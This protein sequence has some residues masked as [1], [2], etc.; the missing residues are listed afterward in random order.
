MSFSGL[1][2]RDIE[3][4]VAIA[5]AGSFTAAAERCGV[6]QPSLSGQ[7]RK[8]EAQL[9]VRIFERTGRDVRVTA[10]GHR[11]IEQA[12]TVLGEARRLFDIARTLNDPLSGPLRLGVIATLGPYLVP[13]LLGPIRERFPD[14]RLILREGLTAE[15]SAL[16]TSGEIDAVLLSLPVEDDR[17][18]AFPILFER[19]I[20]ICSTGSSFAH[21]S[22]LS[23]DDLDTDDLL[24]MD[25]GHCIRD[26][27]LA[28]CAR[29]RAS[30]SVR[31]AASIET[32]RHLVAAG[33]GHALM[34]GL[35]VRQDPLLDPHIAYIPL[36]DPS[37]G[38]MIGLAW[39]K[40]DVRGPSFQELGA[41][42]AGLGIGK[43]AEH[44]A[45]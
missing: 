29:P 25:E 14:L 23:L 24:L 42:I 10:A 8:V 17:L 45:P 22:S 6:S 35:A 16:V 1:S 12:R 13:H 40:T 21:Q 3:Y 44:A 43:S 34:P 11:L 9:G 7:I 38:R 31:H 33:A 19:F 37:I 36:S 41:F 2:L 26:Q 30:R 20:G 28:L 15:L 39:R 5:D 4:V 32:L 27:A 18:T